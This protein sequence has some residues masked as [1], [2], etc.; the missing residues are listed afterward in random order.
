MSES[1][2][3]SAAEQAAIAER[4][5]ELRAQR[6]GKKK[7]DALQD[8]LATIE[9]MPEP[10]RALAVAVHRIVTEVAPE[11]DPRTWYGM[12]A[13]ARDTDVLVFL[14]VSSKFGVRYTTLG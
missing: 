4:A 8:L 1:T 14:Q 10:D 13:Y 3:F 5:Q 7:A 12:P 2:G 11:L 6:G 9:E